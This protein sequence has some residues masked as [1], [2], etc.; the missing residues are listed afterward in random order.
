MTTLKR[1]Q[2]VE[3]IKAAQSF[4][5][6]NMVEMRFSA[7]IR[8]DMVEAQHSMTG[9]I[10]SERENGIMQAQLSDI[11]MELSAGGESL[12][13]S[14]IDLLSR[15]RRL[16]LPESVQELHNRTILP[17]VLDILGEQLTLTDVRTFRRAATDLASDFAIEDQ[18]DCVVDIFTARPRASG[19]IS[20][21]NWT[22]I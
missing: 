14:D 18:D 16:T 2:L 1:N 13:Q 6:V 3:L 20:N 4:Q 21:E 19:G 9:E 11:L 5:E 7:N 10:H 17:E 12:T 22:F 8:R 15:Y